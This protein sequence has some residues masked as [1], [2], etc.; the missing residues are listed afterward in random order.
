MTAKGNTMPA[1]KVVDEH[2][3]GWD[4]TVKIGNGSRVK[5]AYDTYEHQATD[6]FGLGKSLSAVQVMEL[7]AYAGGSDGLDEFDAVVSKEVE[8]F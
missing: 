2:K 6:K 8:E 4:S 7:V 1:P 3:H 5:V